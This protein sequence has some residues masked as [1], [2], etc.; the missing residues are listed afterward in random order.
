MVGLVQQ[1][2]AATQVRHYPG[3]SRAFVVDAPGGEGFALQTEGCRLATMWSLPSGDGGNLLDLSELTT[4]HI[5]AIREAYGVEAARAAIVSEIKAVFGVYGITVDGRHLGL[6]ADYM[7]HTGGYTPLNRMG[8]RDASSPC[9]QMSF[10][11]T[12]TF[13]L[14][15]A[16]GG[17]GD[18]LKSPSGRIVVGRPGRFGTG[19]FDLMVPIES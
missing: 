12:A 7:T 4:N 8:M 17:R 10:E 16:V 18:Q 11:T 5:W 3:I 6:I 9:L 19:A 14:D 1:A 2:L 15:A 13:L